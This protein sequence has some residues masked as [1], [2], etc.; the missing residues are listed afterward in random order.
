MEGIRTLE[1][2]RP[3]HWESYSHSRIRSRV[4]GNLKHKYS[5]LSV[6][7]PHLPTR[8]APT[9]DGPCVRRHRSSI[10]MKTLFFY[11]QSHIVI[12]CYF[13][14]FIQVIQKCGWTICKSILCPLRRNN[15]ISILIHTHRNRFKQKGDVY[16]VLLLFELLSIHFC[17]LFSMDGNITDFCFKATLVCCDWQSR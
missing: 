3:R 17:T 14:K 12:S 11:F 1:D 13:N 2:E 10:W 8:N 9:S 6:T 15:I 5:S 4:C 7:N 16:N